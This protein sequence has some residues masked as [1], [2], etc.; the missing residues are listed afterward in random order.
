MTKILYFLLIV[1]LLEGFLTCQTDNKTSILNKAEECLEVYPDSTIRML[2][3][4]ANSSFE[5][6]YQRA[7]FALLWTQASHKCHIPLENDSLINIAVDYYTIQEERHYAAKA[8]LYKGLVHKQHKEVEKAAEAFA[9]SEQWFEG[10]KD[11]QYKALLYNHYGAL[12]MKEE[13][14]KDA[15]YYLKKSYEFKLRG[16]SIH[17]IVS[18]CGAIA[19]TFELLGQMDSAKIYFEKGLKYKEQISSRRYFLFLQNYANFLRK[20]GEYSLAEEMLQECILYI[21]GE[22]RYS[23]YSCLATLYYDTKN[24]FQSLEYA[25]KMQDSQDSLILRGCYLHMYRAYH[26]L[27]M[28]SKATNYRE[29]YFKYHSD[30]FTRLKT[31]EV[32]KVPHQVRIQVLQI[33]NQQKERI[34]WILMISIIAILTIGVYLYFFIRKRH[35]RKERSLRNVLIDEKKLHQES[36]QMYKDENKTYITELEKSEQEREKLQAQKNWLSGKMKDLLS[37]K[38]TSIEKIKTELK[39]EKGKVK[40][41]DKTINCKWKKIT[42]KRNIANWKRKRIKFLKRTK[43]YRKWLMK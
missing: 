29:L 3:K 10:V 13:N 43:S 39:T 9:M 26:Q 25:Q 2:E 41:R 35:K 8:L 37:R 24:Y 32:A 31:T 23:V 40:D 28:E 27:G 21:K 11:D 7:K 5:F 34:Q 38:D 20:N 15:L 12:M 22:E 1:C 14:Y 42:S 19:N 4:I 36:L 33:E 18:A 16:D 6:D 17:Y 30:I